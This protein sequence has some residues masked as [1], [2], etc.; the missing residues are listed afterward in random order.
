[1]NV[2]LIPVAIAGYLIFKGLEKYALPSEETAEAETFESEY[3]LEYI[4]PTPIS[5]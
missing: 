5:G 3:S 1:M 2:E 4:N